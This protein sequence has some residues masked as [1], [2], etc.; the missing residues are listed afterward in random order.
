MAIRSAWSSAVRDD[1][2]GS[3]VMSVVG[4]E[5]ADEDP[6]VEMDQCH[7]SRSSASSPA[8]YPP[9]SRAGE[10]G[11]HVCFTLEHDSAWT[12]SVG[13]DPLT[14]LQTGGA[15]RVR[16]NRDLVLRADARCPAT[17]IPYF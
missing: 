4:V 16:G 2:P 15:K 7:S 6:G 5:K 13:D 9:V 8:S 10:L 3:R 11:E 12:I 14:D 1:R 17:P